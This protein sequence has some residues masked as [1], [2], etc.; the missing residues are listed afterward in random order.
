[1][2]R[3]T[4]TFL[5][6]VPL[7][8]LLAGGQTSSNSSDGVERRFEDAVERLPIEEPYA[9]HKLLSN[10]P[11][12]H[13]RRDT[14]LHPRANELAL[15]ARGW[16]IVTTPGNSAVLTNAVRDFQ[17]YL[18]TSMAVRAELDSTASLGNWKSLRQAIIA[19]T[20]DQLP[21]CGLKLKRAKGYEI[22]VT[23]DRIVVCGYD[24]RGT[25]YGLYHLEARMNLREAPYLPAEWTSTRHSLYDT[26]MVLSWMGWMEFPDALLS[27]LA[28][29]GF[30]AIYASVYANSNGDRTTAES[31]TDFYARLLF[32]VRAQDPARMRDLIRRAVQYG[33]KVYAPII[34]QYD[35]TAESEATLRR[36]VQQVIRDVPDVKGYVL[37]TEGFWY[38]QWGGGRAGGDSAI[39]HWTSQWVRAVTIVTEECRRINPDIEVL[40]WDYNI[41]NRRENADLKRDLIRQLPQGASPLLTWEN[42]K[43][44]NLDGF[45]GHL[46]DYSISQAGPAE[47]TEV[48]IA[49]AR[50]RGMKVYC[51]ADTFS[52]GGQLQTIP[53]Q[54]FPQQW[55]ARYNALEK[56]GVDGTLE[57]WSAGYTP[58]IMSEFRAWYSWS[59]APPVE[60]LLTA[61]A[62]RGFGEAA[63][64]PV[65]KAWNLFSEAIRFLP[66][67]G[68]T[69]GTSNA[70]GNPL[71]FEQPPPR[72]AT[73]HHSW[74]DHDK[75]MG[76]FGAGLNPYWPFT[77]GRL[78]FMPDFTNRTNKAELYAR[79]ASGINAPKDASIL[80]VFL[81]YLQLA[82]DR[83]G[84]GLQLYRQAALNAPRDKRD[85][86]V[87]E[88]N[89]A[90]QAH[91]MFLSEHAL[92][93]FEDLRL[94][95]AAAPDGRTRTALPERLKNIAIEE[96]VRTERS[97]SAALRDSRLGFQFECDYVY[98]PYSL[99]EKLSVMREMVRK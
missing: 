60:E 18:Q 14:S 49:E 21:G 8:L 64:P 35:G 5:Q 13:S 36:L 17:D 79:S 20:R 2:H 15:P 73:F 41:A 56:H 69:M 67:T 88:V 66:D 75:W 32:R 87:R 34:Y 81:K 71:F 40:P 24:D 10:G 12:H 7:C 26:R 31:S 68:P 58:N 70:I 28:H 45:E 62:R 47:V 99:Q 82:A 4:A 44:F 23:R 19:G 43:S 33:I 42:G 95:L 91:R 57:S 22:T 93:E 83:M 6:T 52:C 25:A 51:N 50:K 76:Y 63:A 94:R 54:P 89:L 55:Y 86:A 92:L 16:R 9:Y 27:H 46:N 48:Q 74:K 84:E 61:I 30:D 98:T 96:I 90:A 65:V 72:T 11:V 1:M 39:R 38:G 97:R 78:T 80:P 29:D 53:Y 59:D 37:L 85:N 3:L 77:L